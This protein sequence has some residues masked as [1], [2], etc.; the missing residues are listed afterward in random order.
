MDPQVLEAALLITWLTELNFDKSTHVH[1][2]VFY[3]SV[4]LYRCGA[5]RVYRFSPLEFKFQIKIVRSNGTE[6]YTAV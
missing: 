4:P 6:R 3:R 5:V 2:R 1:H